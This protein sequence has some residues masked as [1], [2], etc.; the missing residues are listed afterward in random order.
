MKFIIVSFLIWRIFLIVI[1]S[2]SLLVIPVRFGFLGGGT[3]NYLQNPLLWGWANMDGQHYLSLAQNGYFQFEQAFFPLYPLLIRFFGNLLRGNYLLSAL[4]ISHFSFLGSLIIFYKLLGQ[5]FSLK[6]AKWV[7]ISLLVFPTSFFFAGV[8][9]ESLFF[10]LT[11]G[12]VYSLVKKKWLLAGI[13]AGLASATRLV[14]I[15]L[16]PVFFYEWWKEKKK[17]I[18][19]FL[20]ILISPMGLLFYMFYLWRTYADPLMFF[21]VQPAFGAGRS[22]EKIILLPQVLYRYLKIFTTAQLSYDYLIAVFEFVV[23]F[24]AVYLLLR[25]YKQISLPYLLFGWLVLLTPTLS[26][27]LS[28]IPRY[29][30]IN[31]PLMIILGRLEGKVKIISLSLS[32]LLLILVTMF[33]FRGYFV[34]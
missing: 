19:K 13:L 10:F 9:T 30:L 8:Y 32:L 20:A 2:L 31:F 17:P 29:L 26:G 23:F 5:E 22:G 7:I 27:T 18:L 24:L 33:F 34:S 6:V 4:L 1:T 14:G 28:S 25:Y 11:I 21:H 12:S 3:E 16:L 15:F